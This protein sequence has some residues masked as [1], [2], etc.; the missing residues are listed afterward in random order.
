MNFCLVPEVPFTVEHFLS[1]LRE[2]LERRSHALIVVAEG[3]GQ[4]LMAK[5]QERD[6]SGNVKYGDIGVFLSD[7]IKDHFQRSGTAITLKY[8]D[9]SYTIRSVPA[10]AH[11]SAFCLLLGQSAVHAGLS[12]RTNMVVS[13]WNHQFTHVP[14]ALAVSERKKLDPEGALWSSVLASTGQPRD[15]R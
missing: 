4:D 7:A 15:M 2:R 8:I 9:P 14:I 11:D 12:G 13:F 1:A 6:A 10:T 5:S 3:A